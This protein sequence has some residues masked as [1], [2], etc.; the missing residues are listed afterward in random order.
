MLIKKHADGYVVSMEG[1]RKELC[2]RFSMDIEKIAEPGRVPALASIFEPSPKND[3]HVDRV[4][5]LGMVMSVMYIARLTRADIL[6]LTVYLAT[7]GQSPT[8]KNYMGLCRILKYDKDGGPMSIH[9]KKVQGV[10]VTINANSGHG[11]YPDE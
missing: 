4:R 6:L 10:E 9:F 5:Y 1:Y 11:M 2:S 8:L 3:P 7:K